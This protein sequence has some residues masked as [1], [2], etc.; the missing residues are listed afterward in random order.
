MQQPPA[1]KIVKK[2][3]RLSQSSIRQAQA[4]I[5]AL[6]LTRDPKMNFSRYLDGL[7]QAD[8]NEESSASP[9]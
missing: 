3:V 4:K 7:I 9:Q 1:N 5:E 8:L 6:R 2:S